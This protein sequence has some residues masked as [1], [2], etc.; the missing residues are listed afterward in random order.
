MFVINLKRIIRF[1][2]NKFEQSDRLKII[3]RYELTKQSELLR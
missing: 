2:P 1:F 3:L